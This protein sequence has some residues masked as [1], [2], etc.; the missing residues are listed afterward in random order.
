MSR[1]MYDFRMFNKYNDSNL[2]V[3][4]SGYCES[5]RNQFEMAT[6]F[7]NINTNKWIKAVSLNDY[8][9]LKESDTYVVEQYFAVE[10]N[11]I[12]SEFSEMWYKS[13]WYKYCID[14]PSDIQE[15]R[16]DYKGFY[17]NED[18]SMSIFPQLP[19]LLRI[20]NNEL[21]L[22]KNEIQPFLDL[23]PNKE[24]VNGEQL[25]KDCVENEKIELE[26]YKTMNTWGC[27]DYEIKESGIN[28]TSKNIMI[29]TSVINKNDYSNAENIVFCINKTWRHICCHSEREKKILDDTIKYILKNYSLTPSY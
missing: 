17:N 15:F 16:N 22:L 10:D 25:I 14:N 2:T 1:S 3:T 21:Y 4:V 18:M 23:F 9:F 6:I 26:R 8:K 11:I 28:S 13:L 24:P 20:F 12:P 7:R 27:A 29:L 5:I 19:I